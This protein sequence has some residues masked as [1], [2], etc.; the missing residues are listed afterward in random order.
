[1]KKLILK[2]L[3][4]S[5]PVLCCLVTLTFFIIRW[6]P[7]GPFDAE[8][9][10]PADVVAQLNAYYGYDQP[11]LKQYL[12]YLAH[13]LKGDF[14]P[15][16]RYPGYSVNQ[17]LGECIPV[18]FELGFWAML[19]AS[20]VGG[21]VGIIAAIKV[22]TWIDRTLMGICLLGLCLPTFVIGPFIIFIFSLK[23]GWFQAIG[24]DYLSDRIL[25]TITLACMYSGYIAR[26]MRTCCLEILSSPFIKTAYAKGLTKMRILIFH[27]LKNALSPVLTYLGPTAAA[28]MSGSLVIESLFQIPGAGSLFITAVGQRDSALLIGTVLY[29]SL[30]II[31][32]NL[33]VDV[34]IL[35]LDPRQ[36]SDSFT[37]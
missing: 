11:L 35:L 37:S 36:K 23:L 7:G 10:L 26:L 12:H 32:F 5:I 30:L 28:I 22:N 33:L 25:P 17:L 27:M 29:F 24:W 1:M 4:E 20:C 2:R 6:V 16:M 34:S 8:N 31:I 21:S 13:L 18:S 15:S 3:L 14:G 19:L 9:N